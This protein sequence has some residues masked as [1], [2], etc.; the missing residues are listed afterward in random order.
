MKL[1]ES[2]LL[3]AELDSGSPRRVFDFRGNDGRF[4]PRNPS[5]QTHASPMLRVPIA[6][7]SPG[8]QLALPVL[9][10][11]RSTMLLCEGF[12]LDRTLIRKLREMDVPDIWIEYPGTEQIKQYVSPT[13][14][15]QQ[16]RLVGLVAGMFDPEQREAHADVEFDHYR[17]AIRGLIESLVFE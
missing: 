13:I 15:H 6:H 4:S 5:P 3:Y 10:P 12:F 14:L 9:H 1:V 2:C 17:R 16:S 8:M 11:E 7:A